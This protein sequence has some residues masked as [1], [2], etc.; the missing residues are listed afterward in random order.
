[1]HGIK[2]LELSPVSRLPPFK[3]QDNLL[4]YGILKSHLLTRFCQ[5]LKSSG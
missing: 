2:I 5:Y 4:I 3:E 1:M